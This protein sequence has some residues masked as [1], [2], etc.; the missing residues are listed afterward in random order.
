MIVP[1]I[2]ESRN[3][4]T[5]REMVY[6]GHW[7]VPTMNGNI[8]LEK[9]PLPTWIT[10]VSEMMSPD[11]LA[12]QRGMAGLAAVFLVCYF[13]LFAF[14]ILRLQPLIPTLVLC[15]CYNII[16]IGRTASWDIYC[17]AFMMAGIYYLAIALQASS[18]HW[19]HFI[20]SGL[21]IGL[22]F[23]SKG[24]VSLYALFL[25]FLCSYL[26]YYRP[27]LKGKT[28]ALIFMIALALLI[29]SW[30]Y[31]Y[32]FFFHSEAISHVIHK[33]TDAWVNHNVRPWY[34]YWKFFLETGVWSFM[35]LTTLVLPFFRK[36]KELSRKYLFALTWML[37]SLILLSLLPE[38]K[39]RYLLPLLI[40]ASYA[41][42][43]LIAK[44]ARVFK[45]QNVPSI[46]KWAFRINTSLIAAVIALLPIAAYLFV[47]SPGFISIGGWIAFSLFAIAIAVYLVMATVQLHPIRLLCGVTTLFLAAECFALPALK[48]VINNPDMK[49]ISQTR[50]IPQLKGIPFYYNQNTPLR[51]ELVYQA[52]RTIRPLNVS[53]IDSIRKR[54]PCVILTSK[55]VS[56][57]LPAALWKDVD[58]VYVNHYDDNR[59]PKGNYRYDNGFIY[60]V[61][62]LKEKSKN[63]SK[64]I[65]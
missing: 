43:C 52:N 27:S 15:T 1:D 14:R 28:R 4:I 18:C 33:E 17:H 31:L 8:R 60:H 57:E 42:G 44:W 35:L 40:P 61:T 37:L 48:N 6:D 49:S 3:I 29:S 9:P 62:L 16:L 23:M 47:Y 30:W 64:Q 58:S 26:Y 7:I 22:S 50:D 51:I 34:Y 36:K 39:N 21:C 25:P 54:L 65:K 19:K 56:Q 55:R 38:K 2:M 10:A 11:N 46:D 13:Y 45:R 63:I 59:R 41:I 53:C 24:P 5:A 12:L 32:I 20:V